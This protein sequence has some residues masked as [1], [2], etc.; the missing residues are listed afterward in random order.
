[1]DPNASDIRYLVART[2]DMKL[3]HP[4]CSRDF[5]ALEFALEQG[6]A[7]GNTSTRFRPFETYR[8][9]LRQA[10]AYNNKTSRARAYQSAHQFGLAVDFVPWNN[11]RW[12]WSETHDWAFLEATAKTFGLIR[13]IAWDLAHVEAP[14][15]QD[16]KAAWRSM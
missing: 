7:R 5:L 16:L 2:A 15:F 13:S 11:G 9:P 6:F 14:Q 8:H 3:L 4:T 12:S 10:E 1:M